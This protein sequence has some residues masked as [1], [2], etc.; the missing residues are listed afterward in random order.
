MVNLMTQ[1]NDFK[2]QIV[3]RSKEG[4]YPGEYRASGR[5]YLNTSQ[6]PARKSGSDRI[7]ATYS[8]SCGVNWSILHP[9]RTHNLQKYRRWMQ[10][11]QSG[12]GNSVVVSAL[13]FE[14]ANLL[15]HMKCVHYV[16]GRDNNVLHAVEHV[17]DRR[18]AHLA[19][20]PRRLVLRQTAY[21]QPC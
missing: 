17:R 2:L 4:S 18:T 12:A 16:T 6:T 19:I 9:A 3:A 1:C 21:C 7:V 8:R 11:P 5:R 10:F 13:L 15:P 20:E 14:C